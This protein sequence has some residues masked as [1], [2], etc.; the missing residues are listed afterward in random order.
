MSSQTVKNDEKYEISS[1]Y[2]AYFKHWLWS[3]TITLFHVKKYELTF[4]ISSNNTDLICRSL[5]WQIKPDD[6]MGS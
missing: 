3:S 1:K 6:K 5:N 4:K 2:T